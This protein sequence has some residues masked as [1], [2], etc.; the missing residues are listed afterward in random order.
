MKLPLAYSLKNR[1]SS[2]SKDAKLLN[3]YVESRGDPKKGGLTTVEKRPA[4]DSAFEL[5]SGTGQ[6]LYV[7]NIPGGDGVG[8][9][10]SDVLGVVISDILTRAPTAKKKELAFGVQPS[11]V[12]LNTAISPSVT[13]RILDSTGT[14]VTSA[15]DAI[16]V[17]LFSNSTGAT[18]G[19]TTTRNAVSGVATFNDLTLNR[20]G[21]VFTLQATG[22]ALNSAVSN[23]FAITTHLAFTVQP[24]GA[25]PNAQ[26]SV[27]V[28][29]QDS[30]NVTDTN[31]SK[32]ITVDVFSGAGGTLSGNTSRL[33]VNG[34]IAFP[35][36]SI[37]VEG[38]SYTLKATAEE[39]TD[40]Y[41]PALALSNSFAISTN[42]I[43][44]ATQHSA[45]L[46][47]FGYDSA[48]NF[49]GSTLSPLTYNGKTIIKIDAF[50]PPA[51]VA[52]TIAFSDTT[53]SQNF[54]TSIT[55]NSVTLLSAD[56]T[57]GA[58]VWTWTS[59]SRW[60]T[61]AGSYTVAFT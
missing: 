29:A 59:G 52:N 3:G 4:L 10:G 38:S 15:T 54:F 2:L 34:E 21:A 14:L 5:T 18:L 49:P 26:F 30:A 24:T 58:G 9:P 16:T 51:D 20:S 22:T 41:P 39:D 42:N 56:A 35:G 37:D 1:D 31:Y 48:G 36:L 28:A 23:A 32:F 12:A 53:L 11:N 25:A 47:N 43:L 33:A 13:V 19:G 46:T 44:G 61:A 27:T 45:T 57:Y 17:A 8:V 60:F 7:L 40:A 50:A 55:I 6:A